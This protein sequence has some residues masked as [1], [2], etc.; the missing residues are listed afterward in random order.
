VGTR[1]STTPL[2]GAA[3]AVRLPRS[4]ARAIAT[5][6]RPAVLR[7]L[8][9]LRAHAIKHDPAHLVHQVAAIVAPDDAAAVPHAP[10]AATFAA[11]DDRAVSQEEKEKEIGGKGATAAL[12]HDPLAS[13]A[14]DAS[15]PNLRV[16][17]GPT[18]ENL[19][20]LALLAAAPR[21][22]SSPGNTAG[23]E[24]T[25]SRRGDTSLTQWM[26]QRNKLRK[27]VLEPEQVA[28]CADM[29]ALLDSNADGVIQLDEMARALER[30][31]IRA[32]LHRLKD[33]LRDFNPGADGIISYVFCQRGGALY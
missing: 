4:L 1:P 11:V 25:P 27:T 17:P 13:S 10:A 30:L 18:P 19:A 20:S 15:P 7:E 33:S 3:G 23:L 31:G 28:R 5:P 8:A 6:H 24:S 26:S 9:K 21:P 22:A 12:P 2:T 32:D 16:R 29:F 14:T